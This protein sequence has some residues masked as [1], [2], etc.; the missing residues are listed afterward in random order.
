MIVELSEQNFNENVK[1]GLK[2]VEFYTPWCGYCK[3][4][5]NVFF[6]TSKYPSWKN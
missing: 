5:D 1:D 4:Q 6:R 3:K 2:L